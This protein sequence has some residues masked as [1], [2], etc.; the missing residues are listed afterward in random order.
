MNDPVRNKKL[1]GAMPWT[2][3]LLASLVV[4][5][6]GWGHPAPSVALPVFSAS[7]PAS[8]A[9]AATP[10]AL[11]PSVAGP[12]WSQAA[13]STPE[14][15]QASSEQNFT[16]KGLATNIQVLAV[17][18]LIIALVLVCLLLDRILKEGEHEE[19]PDFPEQN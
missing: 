10:S 1:L 12:W 18:V 17:A 16:L 13:S 14:Q 11:S 6:L 19:H 5:A 15:G 2:R 3:W 8:Y 9:A 7:S 4:L